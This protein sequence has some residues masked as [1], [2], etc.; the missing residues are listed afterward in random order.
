[1]AGTPADDTGVEPPVVGDA[2]PAHPAIS[3]TRLA[4]PSASRNR[5]MSS[6]PACVCTVEIKAGV[7][8]SGIR[9]TTEN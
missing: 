1:V 4:I 2:A 8:D 3:A 5:S 7:A 9:E 6:P